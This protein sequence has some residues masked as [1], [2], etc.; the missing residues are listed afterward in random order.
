MIFTLNN[1]KRISDLPASVFCHTLNC[2]IAKFSCILLPQGPGDHQEDQAHVGEEVRG[3]K[4]TLQFQYSMRIFQVDEQGNHE[5]ERL[6][7]LQVAESCIF[8]VTAKNF[9]S[10]MSCLEGFC[11]D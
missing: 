3:R 8:F 11:G 1:Q 10:Q 2:N 5:R 7:C 4:L 9:A 6:S